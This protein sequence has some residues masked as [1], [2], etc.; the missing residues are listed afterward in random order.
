MRRRES[1]WTPAGRLHRLHQAQVLMRIHL[2]QPEVLNVCC[3]TCARLVGMHRINTSARKKKKKNFAHLCCRFI[4]CAESGK[5]IPL[6]S[7]RNVP[8]VGISRLTLQRVRSSSVQ[9]GG[10][11]SQV[12]SDAYHVYY[13]NR[14]W[15]E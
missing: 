2:S 3:L 1:L 8:V 7:I 14:Q 13:L 12:M 4:A 11:R 9:G 5:E 6:I 15:Q 10:Q